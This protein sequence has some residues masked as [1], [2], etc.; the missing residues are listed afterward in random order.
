M[1]IR[2]VL[3][4]LFLVSR[5]WADDCENWF[6]KA[7]LSSSQKDC[8]LECSSTKVDLGT[9]QCP[10]QCDRLCKP[11]AQSSAGA[12]SSIIDVAGLSKAELELIATRPQEA[13]VVY[14]QVEMAQEMTKKRFGRDWFDDESD[15]Y[16]H[17]V[18]TGLLVKELGAKDAKMFLDAH[19]AAN[20]PDD[21]G[22]Q[23]DRRNNE[24]A[25]AESQKLKQAG[26]LDS[27][28]LDQEAVRALKEKKLVVL[29]PLGG[30]K[31]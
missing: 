18:W 14:A 20:L 10:E 6:A 9:M 15:A 29:R 27:D 28:H 17:F 2:T 8:I 11:K 12:V 26:H 23:M 7:H 24:Y 19:E 16:R 25:M 31:K 22:S 13:R 30:P 5:A 21:P 4:F 1:S 3:M